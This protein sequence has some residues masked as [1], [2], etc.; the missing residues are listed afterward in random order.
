M[1]IGWRG[2]LKQYFNPKAGNYSVGIN[3]VELGIHISVFDTRKNQP[4]WIKQHFIELNNWPV[5][6][7]HWI[8]QQGLRNC[9]CNIVLSSMDYHI[10]QVERPSV[11]EEELPQALRWAIKDLIP[12]KQEQVI[13]YFEHPA[14]TA[15]TNKLSVVA[16]SRQ[17]INDLIKQIN[18]TDLQLSTISIQEMAYCELLPDTDEGVILLT[19]DAGQD[20]YINIVKSGSL[21]FTR[22]LRGYELLSSLSMTEI[23]QDLLVSLATETQRSM[24]YMESQLRQPPINKVVLALDTDFQSEL[25]EL[26]QQQIFISVESVVPQITTQANLTPR[27]A[28]YVSLGAGLMQ[29][30]GKAVSV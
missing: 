23:Q 3:I 2:A 5:A 20:L 26:L 22:R 7:K 17:R 14:Q 25:A 19:Q 24:D 10:L 29:T 12:D 11:P 28:Y 27:H 16:V 30:N 13:D 6:L 18:L 9:P 8:Q 1:H 4:G 15:G 21:Y